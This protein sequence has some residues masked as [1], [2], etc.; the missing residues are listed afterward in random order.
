MVPNQSSC[1]DPPTLDINKTFSTT[2]LPPTGCFLLWGSSSVNTRD[3]CAGEK[4]PVDQQQ[5]AKHS[6]HRQ[7]LDS[8]LNQICPHVIGKYV[9]CIRKNFKVLLKI[10]CGECEEMWNISSF[11]HH[12]EV[13]PCISHAHSPDTKTI[14]GLDV[15]FFHFSTFLVPSFFNT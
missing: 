9:I 11:Y 14:V 12:S 7:R 10:S 2:Q 4:F 13:A 1:Y 8:R 3:G 6:D 15:E 5:F